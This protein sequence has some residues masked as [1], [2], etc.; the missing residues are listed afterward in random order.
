MAALLFGLAGA[1]IGTGIGGAILG[2]S[3]AT[4]GGFIGSTIGSYVDSLIIASLQP[5]IRNEGPR[6]QEM[7]T[8]ATA[9][10]RPIGRLYGTMQV[11]GNLI[12]TTRFREEKTTKT[13]RVGGKGGGGGQKVENTT[14]AYFVS[15]AVAFG[16][17]NSRTILGRVWADGKEMDLSEVNYTFYRG[18]ESQNPDA[19][20][21]SIE[22]AENTPAFRGIAYI[23]FEELPLA[24]FGNRIPQITAEVIRPLITNDPNDISNC[25]T[26]FCVIPG[27]GEFVYGT[28]R[29]TFQQASNSI[30]DSFFSGGNFSNNLGDVLARPS[31]TAGSAPAKPMNVNNR[32]NEPDFI[33]SMRQ[34]GLLQSNLKTVSLVVGWF[35][36]DLRVGECEIRPKVEF[37]DRG[38][39]VTP[40]EWNVAGHTR[41]SAAIFETSRDSE[42]RPL[43]GGTPSDDVVVEAIQWLKARGYKVVFYPFIFMDIPPGNTLPNPYS[44]NAA[45]LGQP[46]FPWRGRITCSPALGFTGTVSKTSAAA[47]QVT[48]FFTR[49]WGFNNFITHYAN[50]CAAAG[51]VDAFIIGTEMVGL[52]SIRSNTTTGFPSV[53]RLVTLANTV[54]GIVGAGTKIGY[55]ADWSEYHSYKEGNEVVFNMDPLWATANID[56]IGIDN[57]LPLSDWRDGSDHLDYDADNGVV[58]PHN[59]NYLAANVEGGEYFDWFYASQA[60][61]DNQ[62]R[63][64]ITDGAHGK[65]WVFRQKDLR[66][67]WSNQHIRRNTTGAE[68]GSPT[69]WVPQS[70]PIWFTEFGCPCV[71]KGTNQPNVFYDP[72]SSESFF[73]YYSNGQQDEYISRIYAE[74]MVAYWRDNSPTSSVYSGPMIHQDDMHLWCWD[75]RPYPDWPLRTD[76]WSDG[77]LWLYGHWMTGRLAAPSL[78]R[79]I[80]HFCAEVGVTHVNVEK[81]YG[82]QGLIRGYY[83]DRVMA[84]RDAIG[85]LMTGFQFDAFESQGTLKFALKSTTTLVTL[86]PDQ[87]VSAENNQTGLQVTRTQDTELPQAI[88]VDFMNSEEDYIVSTVDA[89]RHTVD[90]KEVAQIQLPIS[91]PMAYVK[92]L[93]DSILHQAWA[94]RERGSVNLPPSMFRLDPGDG[95]A[96]P[97]GP[98][99]AYGRVTRIDT[100]EWREVEFQGF[101]LSLYQL[102]T[103]PARLNPLRPASI[104]GYPELYVLDI[105]LVTGAEPNH[106]SPRLATWAAPWPGAVAVYRNQ[107][108]LPLAP[109]WDL[110]RTLRS[111]A[112]MGVLTAPVGLAK[113]SVWLDDLTIEVR[114]FSGTLSVATDLEVLNGANACAIQNSAGHWEIFQYANR[115]L[116]PDGSYSLSRLI[117]G[118]LGTEWVMHEAGGFATGSPFVLLDEVFSTNPVSAPY[119]PVG[120]N[121]RDQQVFLRF[122]SIRRDVGDAGAYLEKTATVEAMAQKPY[123]PVHLNATWQPSGNID[124]SWKRRA[125]FNADDWAPPEIPLNEESERYHLQILDGSSNVIREV[126]NLTVPAYTYTNAMQT[127]DFGGPL[128]ISVTFRV[129][130]ISANVGRGIPAQETVTK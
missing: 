25:V 45:T 98:N 70:K 107:T 121:D 71:D 128:T 60:D 15:C 23:V 72:K 61:R 36:S 81:L 31:F 28:D 89:K 94:A 90:T 43:Y 87:F 99:T 62:V 44:N 68:T 17:G 75:S 115:V 110:A 59:P 92:G 34:L 42:G 52:T 7:K 112:T 48:T 16:E 84:V 39:L 14:Y 9:E 53:S 29:Y 51:G 97:L 73:P 124:L 2:V 40:R 64:P 30:L 19:L 113:P 41:S 95:I 10:G 129:F 116:N 100:G 55:A 56:F 50:L 93:A 130:Q 13:E 86:D 58:S 127:S 69:A 125:R 38:G 122:G 123:A 35:G 5:A 66:S 118:Q 104:Q 80:Q 119:L 101:D 76:V 74:V 20:I 82:G 106:W 103:Y 111:R 126:T 102:P 108:P 85:S 96:F 22:G 11:P 91:L 46:I 37:K 78:P 117:R 105:P 3:A 49:T 88:Q 8:M 1:A 63:T 32:D 26:G 67:W 57:Y 65:P 109:T 77:Q 79:L 83:L 54:R 12:W 120:P 21:Q 6:L 27:S 24:A 4:I 114:L 47:D 33:R 18:T